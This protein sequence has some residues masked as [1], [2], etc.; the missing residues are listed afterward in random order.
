MASDRA[1]DLV[2][3]HRRRTRCLSV[4]WDRWRPVRCTWPWW[5]AKHS[6]WH[7]AESPRSSGKVWRVK[8]A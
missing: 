3:R 8:H 7:C 4:R 5:H 1:I 6:K 2:N